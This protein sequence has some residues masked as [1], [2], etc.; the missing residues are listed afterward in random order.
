MRTPI[1]AALMAACLAVGF[2]AGFEMNRYS[3]PQ[4][5]DRTALTKIVASEYRIVETLKRNDIAAFGRL[6]PDDLIDV[7]ED[8]IH[9]KAHWLRE[10]EEQKQ[11]GFLFTD[12]KFENPRLLRISPDAAVMVASERFGVVEK[13]KPHDV[14]V[15]TQALYVRRAGQW[16]PLVYQD[17]DAH[18][19]RP[20]RGQFQ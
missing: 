1:T 4:E 12:F 20:A 5:D 17:S 11:T 9:D 7:D 13:G 14:H 15:Y 16:V 8:G 3:L 18:D 2:G 10:F 6:L 19:S